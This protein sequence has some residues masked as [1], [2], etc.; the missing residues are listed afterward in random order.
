[1]C[2][3]RFCTNMPRSRTVE[4]LSPAG[5]HGQMLACEYVPIATSEADEQAAPDEVMQ[6]DDFL[7]RFLGAHQNRM[8]RGLSQGRNIENELLR[9][10]MAADEDEDED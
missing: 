2:Y 10:L 7:R 9:F 1:M 6:E 5:N 8:P 3:F 4:D